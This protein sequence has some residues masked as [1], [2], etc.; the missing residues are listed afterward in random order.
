M[1]GK[2]TIR[3]RGFHLNFKEIGM[4][5]TRKLRPAAYF[6]Q[7]NSHSIE[8]TSPDIPIGEIFGGA[9]NNQN[10]GYQ[11]RNFSRWFDIKIIRELPHT[12]KQH[13]ITCPRKKN[14][15][16]YFLSKILVGE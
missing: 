5:K 10:L 2:L 4:R 11:N 7:E 9:L 3:K 15:Y 14:L 16:F 6:A 1:D 8:K 13:L 12:K